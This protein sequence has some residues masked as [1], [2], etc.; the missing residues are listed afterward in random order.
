MLEFPLPHAPARPL[1]A[2]GGDLKCHPAVTRGDRLVML[3]EVGDLAAPDKQDALEVLLDGQAPGALVCDRHP[4]Y[5]S[6]N[7]A[8]RLAGEQRLPLREVQHHRAHVAAVCVE[9]RLFDAPVVGLAF[10]GT[11]FGDDGTVWG[12][13]FFTGSVAG[14]LIRRAHFATVPLPGGDAA[15]RQ[16]WRIALALLLERGAS[17]AQA[18]AYLA[19]HGI[20]LG[21]LPLFEKALANKLAVGRS[22]ALGRWFDAVSALLGIRTVAQFEAQPAIDLQAT[23]EKHFTTKVRGDWPY[24]LGGDEVLVVDFPAL[25]EAA[26]APPDRAPA[27]AVEFHHAAARATAEVAARLA[28]AANTELVVASGGCFLNKLFARLLDE[29]LAAAGLRPLKPVRL[30]PGDQALALGQIGLALYDAP[31]SSEG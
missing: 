14:G 6:T 11:G 4:D 20:A 15:V 12:G 8:H 22:S 3:D 10:D 28:A 17:R 30:P 2:L 24:A 16:P 31:S 5:F 25:A 26:Q 1:L 29:Q 21:D 13:E 27:L 23:A 9:H 19:R 7:L 18:Q